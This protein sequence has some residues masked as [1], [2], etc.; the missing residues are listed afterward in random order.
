MRKQ[1]SRSIAASLAMWLVGCQSN[2]PRPGTESLPQKPA[3][4]ANDPQP[5]PTKP[6][7]GN[8]VP[9]SPDKIAAGEKRTGNVRNND[10]GNPLIKSLERS[11]LFFPT[12]FPDGDWKPA[13]LV[14]E[15]AAFKA[16]DGTRL[17]GWFV[18]HERPRRSSCLPTAT[19]AT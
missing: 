9:T 19:G 8:T 4:A 10:N 17:H 15:D 3:I 13:G 12:K 5:P 1:V 18:P 7:V 11:L 16:A 14:F 2:S 6:A